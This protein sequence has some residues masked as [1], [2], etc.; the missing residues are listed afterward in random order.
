MVE[1]GDDDGVDYQETVELNNPVRFTFPNI[2]DWIFL[3]IIKVKN[4]L[5]F[6]FEEIYTD[7][8]FDN[9]EIAAKVLNPIGE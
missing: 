4:F 7:D 2:Q 3:S 1:D 5:L 6:H 8:C 9:D